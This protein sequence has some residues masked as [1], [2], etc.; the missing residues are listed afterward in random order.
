MNSI[1]EQDI[2]D[3]VSSFALDNEIQG[4]CFL[5]TG[6]TGLIGS[7]LIYCLI[8]L[9]KDIHVIVPVRNKRKAENM[10]NDYMENIRII[11]CD[12]CHYD[13]HDIGNVDYIVHCA[14]PTSSSFFVERPVETFNVIYNASLRLLEYAR[15][16][17][18]RGFIY[19]SSLEVYGSILDSSVVI[20]E[21]FQGYIDPMNVRSCYPLAKRAIENLCCS[22]AN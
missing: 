17:P 21:D 14:A 20:T 8:A 12:I 18:I 22:Y 16:N 7:S 19:L 13:Y 15:N 5:I 3:F 10:F 9:D 1:Q 11:E 4:V 2:A 6:A